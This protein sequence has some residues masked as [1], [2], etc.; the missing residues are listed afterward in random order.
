MGKELIEF[1][2]RKHTR[3]SKGRYSA[4]GKALP[5]FIGT[6]FA[7]VHQAAETEEVNHY[8]EAMEHW[9][10]WEIVHN[11]HT[12]NNKDEAKA[13]FIV[14]GEKGELRWDDMHMWHTLNRL[15]SS[16]TT[17]GAALYIQHTKEPQVNPKTGA[18]VS[19]EDRTKDA[20]DA[21]WGVGTWGEWFSHNI[22]SYN[23]AKKAFEYKGKQLEGDPKGTGGLT[24]ELRRL[25]S[26]WKEGRYVNPME[27]EELIDFGIKYGKMG[28]EDKL[29]FLFEGITATPSKGPAMGETLL[30]MDRIGDLDGQYLNI[31]PMLDF[32][33]N[34]GEKKSHPRYLNG[35]IDLDKTKKG[36][37]VDDYQSYIKEYFP[38]ESKNCTAGKKFSKFLW[39]WMMTDPN[40]R[41]RLAKGLRRAENMDHDDA[42][43][44]IATATVEQTETFVGST[45]GNQKYWTDEG[46]KNGYAGFNHYLVSLSNKVDTLKDMKG[47]GKK[48]DDDMLEDTSKLMLEAVRSYFTFDAY[49]SGRRAPE[50]SRYARLGQQ[51]YDRDMVVDK[52]CKVKDHKEQLDNLV[53]AVCEAYEIDWKKERLFEAPIYGDRRQQEELEANMRDFI[54]NI[55]PAKI[56]EQ[57]YEKLL[58]IVDQRKK[59]GVANVD[60]KNALR[61]LVD[62]NTLLP[63][64]KGGGGADLG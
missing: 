9:G 30:H 33:T 37:T 15:T 52:S 34:K 18:K 8:K 21:L 61:G 39:E 24:N 13:C 5:S 2:K 48:I 59:N 41:T 42:H 40:F 54:Q 35:E 25:L 6:E 28:A 60:D 63:E 32:F 43:M 53:K 12:T 11:L 51:Q 22:N 26:D 10:I 19:G 20:I 7:R 62:I 14:L 16:Y 38:E 55:L 3:R 56:E 45:Q 1:I 50:D 31:F 64:K 44:Y 57:G 58:Q 4:L 27:Y 36:Y 49:L 47:K 17:D 29:F 46:Y 23:N